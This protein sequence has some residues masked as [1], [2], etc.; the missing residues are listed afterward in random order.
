MRGFFVWILWYSS[1][2]LFVHCFHI[3]E[4]WCAVCWCRFSFGTHIACTFAVSINYW[5]HVRWQAIDG[6]HRV[7]MD[8]TTHKNTI[9]H[10]D[11]V[12]GKISHSLS[13]SIEWLSFDEMSIISLNKVSLDW[14]SAFERY[15]MTT[16]IPFIISNS[17]HF[18]SEAKI[19]R[20]IF[21]S[22]IIVS[23]LLVTFWRHKNFT[24]TLVW[25]TRQ[26]LK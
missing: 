8:R 13:Q 3:H 14:V 10:G 12:V 24:F 4:D 19:K 21:F 20:W 18:P 2:V 1:S 11:F 7:L 9:L 23:L 26:L 15:A 17:T 22:L 25:N 6:Q 5:L 16:F